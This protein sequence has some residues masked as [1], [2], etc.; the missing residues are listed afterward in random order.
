MLLKEESK[1]FI[2]QGKLITD[3]GFFVIGVSEDS[4]VEYV[5]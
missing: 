1:R 5:N 3:L 4:M 2:M